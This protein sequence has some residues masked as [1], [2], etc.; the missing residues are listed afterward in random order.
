MLSLGELRVLLVGLLCWLDLLV[1]PSLCRGGGKVEKGT[2]FRPT[3]SNAYCRACHLV[4]VYSLQ[5][6]LLCSVLVRNG[7]VVVLFFLMESAG[8]TQKV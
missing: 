6:S 4:C 1:R 7:N 2:V 3:D 8:K 5:T